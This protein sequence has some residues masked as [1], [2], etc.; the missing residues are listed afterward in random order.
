[1]KGNGELEELDGQLGQILV[2][3]GGL[4][5]VPEQEDLVDPIDDDVVEDRDDVEEGKAAGVH[6]GDEK[7]SEHLG[8]EV[9]GLYLDASIQILHL[10]L[11]ILPRINLVGSI[12]LYLACKSPIV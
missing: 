4:L 1:V 12:A 6:H 2:E 5:V 7:G 9:V 3:G 10:L 8:V 11:R